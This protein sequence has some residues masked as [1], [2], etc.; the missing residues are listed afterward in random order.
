MQQGL[1]TGLIA[2]A[3]SLGC[4]VGLG[5]WYWTALKPSDA[6]QSKAMIQLGQTLAGAIDNSDVNAINEGIDGYPFPIIV[7]DGEQEVVSSNM[8]KSQQTSRVAEAQDQLKLHKDDLSGPIKLGKNQGSIYFKPLS[9]NEIDLNILVM[10][11]ISVL[12]GGSFTVYYVKTQ[13]WLSHQAYVIND[14]NN[15]LERRKTGPLQREV[16]ALEE[17]TKKISSML[18]KAR[19]KIEN[20]DGTR[21]K[22]RDELREQIKQL[23]KD[24]QS[25][26]TESHRQQDKIAHL[27]QNA[28]L[29][30]HQVEKYKKQ[31][32]EAKTIS[33]QSNLPKVAVR[34]VAATPTE[35]KAK[36]RVQE[37]RQIQSAHA[38]VISQQKDQEQKHQDLMQQIRKKESDIHA[39]KKKEEALKL[40]EEQLLAKP[41]EQQSE[42]DKKTQQELKQVRLQLT[43]KVQELQGLNQEYEQSVKRLNEI[44]E[45]KVRVENDLLTMED[46]LDAMTSEFQ[47]LAEER[48]QLQEEQLILS[49]QLD[50]LTQT[51]HG[52]VI[53]KKDE[54][55]RRF[56][57]ENKK[58]YTSMQYLQQKVTELE[59]QLAIAQQQLEHP[60][61]GPVPLYNQRS[62]ADIMEPEF[63]DHKID[64]ANK[65]GELV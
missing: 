54:I 15:Q 19:K 37:I 32:A 12:V 27:E 53:M 2:G 39:I 31:L 7:L 10:L 11:A 30:K 20:E 18:L 33:S 49:Q 4:F 62:L 22:V 1:K 17:K 47:A 40:K 57:D 58:M 25:L 34:T 51:D 64:R 38:S 65:T 61:S 24:N 44:M 35:N 45:E 52:T 56:Q 8:A 13:D 55:T 48:D 41:T 3:I 23:E 60:D 9:H 63:P 36:Q 5:T 42:H 21:Q 28:V 50:D 43:H 16:R 29:L 14:L 46:H 59:N 6:D 26:E